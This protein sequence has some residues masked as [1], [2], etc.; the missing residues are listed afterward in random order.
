[1]KTHKLSMNTLKRSMVSKVY[2]EIFSQELEAFQKE[3]DVLSLEK[4]L[5]I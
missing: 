4:V 3:A 2:Q 5:D 1:M